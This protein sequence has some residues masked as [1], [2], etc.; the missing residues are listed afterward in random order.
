MLLLNFKIVIFKFKSKLNM[1]NREMP[2][3]L[4]KVN[5]RYFSLF[6]ALKQQQIRTFLHISLSLGPSAISTHIGAEGLY[7]K[8]ATSHQL[9]CLCIS[10][11]TFREIMFITRDSEVIMF[12]H[13]VFVCLCVCVSMFVTMFVR[14]I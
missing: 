12:S 6:T 14:T 2:Q 7:V 9:K 8:T 10:D 13:C 3:N 11:C 4:N 5:P 1:D